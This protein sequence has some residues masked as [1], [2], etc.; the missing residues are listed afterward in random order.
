MTPKRAKTLDLVMNKADEDIEEINGNKY[1]AL[2][3]TDE[4]KDNL[5]KSGENIT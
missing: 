5:K 2:V 4:N 3:Y 1:V